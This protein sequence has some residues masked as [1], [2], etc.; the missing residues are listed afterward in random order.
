MQEDNQFEH[1]DDSFFAFKGEGIRLD[2]KKIKDNGFKEPQ[3]QQKKVDCEIFQFFFKFPNLLNFKKYIR[4]IPDYDHD[5]TLLIFDRSVRPTNKESDKPT[6]DQE[7]KKFQG[8][9]KK[10]KNKK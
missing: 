8:E 4:G 6:P 10:L 3:P 1:H 5:I 7:F 9:G 2:G